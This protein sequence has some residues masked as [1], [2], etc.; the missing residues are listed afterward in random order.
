V[1]KVP[2]AAHVVHYAEIVK[3][4]GLLRRLISAANRIIQVG[5]DTSINAS[6]ALDLS[7]QA[8][9]SVSQRFF[10]KNFIA[11]SDLLAE[12]FE[13]IDLLHKNKGMI[14]GIPTGFKE[15]DNMLAGLQRSDLIILA[16][17]PSVGK[18]A[19]ALNMA[20]HVA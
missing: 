13:R 10:N 20:E 5:F 2:S 14:R 6:D 17:R 7:E 9:F 15:L 16:A 12:S 3:E 11:I 8:L 4:K 18:T 1:G 19:L